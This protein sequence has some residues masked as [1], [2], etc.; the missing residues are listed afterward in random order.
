MMLQKI[1]VETLWPLC[2]LPQSKIP[3]FDKDLS[4]MLL[5]VAP[6]DSL[7]D[8]SVWPLFHV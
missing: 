8:K 7:S 4:P 5:V 1:G 3:A 2:H 6:G